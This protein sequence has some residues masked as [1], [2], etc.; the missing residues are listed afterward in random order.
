ML[1]G[2]RAFPQSPITGNY[3]NET[4]RP[5]GQAMMAMFMQY[6]SGPSRKLVTPTTWDPAN[7]NNNTLSGG[8]LTVTSGSGTGLYPD[9]VLCDLWQMVRRNHAGFDRA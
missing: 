4:Q 6:Q 5:A 7:L 3:K 1:R 9:A 8:N 2:Q